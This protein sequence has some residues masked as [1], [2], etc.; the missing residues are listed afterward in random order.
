MP[1]VDPPRRLALS[2]VPYPYYMFMTPERFV[3]KDQLIPQLWTLL[4]PRRQLMRRCSRLWD[5][6]KPP[7]E[8][9]RGILD[10]IGTVLVDGT[11]TCPTAGS[12]PLVELPGHLSFQT[13][14]ANADGTTPACMLIDPEKISATTKLGNKLHP[15]F[16][17]GTNGYTRIKL[18]VEWS[19]AETK[20]GK[21][22]LVRQDI[23]ESVHRFVLW[24]IHGP[25]GS[26]LRKRYPVCMHACHNEACVSP[27]HMRHGTCA[28]NLRDRKR[29]G[30]PTS[31]QE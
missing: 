20:W 5:L 8:A 6:T 10:L 17:R 18:A 31:P 14:L 15:Y 1:R 29:K 28:E 9:I 21:P 13:P 22:V 12:G 2:P 3:K 11:N 23:I 7:T 26:G 27:F 4:D 16:F 30:G 19:M 24:A 25:P